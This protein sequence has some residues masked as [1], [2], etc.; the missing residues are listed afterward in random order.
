[1]HVESKNFGWYRR[2][3]NF[4]I[5]Y[6]IVIIAWGA[7]VRISGSGAGC[8]EHWPL[9]NGKAIPIGESSKTWVEVSHRYS[10]AIF[11]VLAVLL[12]GFSYRVQSNKNFHR[13]GA[14]GVLLFTIFE[15]LIG[16]LLVV[17]GLVDQDLS[18]ARAVLM[19]LHLVNT[20]LLLFA[21][22]LSVESLRLPA[23]LTPTEKST[24]LLL[25]G[26]L[27]IILFTLL[28]T[29]AIAAL[30]THIA[31]SPTFMQGIQADLSP[32]S[33]IAVRLRP[34]HLVAGFASFIIVIF[35]LSYRPKPLRIFFACPSSQSFT[36]WLMIMA[37]LGTA[38]LALHSPVYLKMAHL[39]AATIL[40]VLTSKV[41]LQL[42]FYRFKSDLRRL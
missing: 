42:L 16:R 22:V 25:T 39:V 40:V 5:A 9:C 6:T 3:C 28:T 21:E 1:M 23:A 34:L 36:Y 8:G 41:I 33:H 13:L 11:G 26:S 27:V 10:T 29:G 24:R 18:L 30:A 31:P 20:S 2:Y 12:C 7:W 35:A 17:E 37:L 14:W 38:T 15:A 19:P 4:L 32:S